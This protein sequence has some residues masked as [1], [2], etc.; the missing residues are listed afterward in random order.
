MDACASLGA[1]LSAHELGVLRGEHDDEAAAQEHRDD[2]HHA[3]ERLRATKKGVLRAG[4]T[5]ASERLGDVQAGELVVVLERAALGDGRDRVRCARGWL[6]VVSAKGTVMLETADSSGSEGEAAE[7]AAP[8]AAEPEPEPEQGQEKES[9]PVLAAELAAGAAALRPPATAADRSD[10]IN[11][12]D[13][14]LASIDTQGVGRQAAVLSGAHAGTAGGT[15]PKAAALRKTS[16][17]SLGERGN[18]SQQDRMLAGLSGGAAALLRPAPERRGHGPTLTRKAMLRQMQQGGHVLD[19]GSDNDSDSDGCGGEEVSAASRSA[20]GR[21]VLAPDKHLAALAARG[22]LVRAGISE[23]NMP[24]PTAVNPRDSHLAEV[25]LRGRAQADK[26]EAAA[27]AAPASAG[28]NVRD[29]QLAALSSPALRGRVLR[30][31]AAPA[32]AVHGP[33]EWM[34]AQVRMLLLLLLLVLLLLLLLLLCAASVAAA[35]TYCCWF[36][37]RW[38]AALAFSTRGLRMRG[39]SPSR[40]RTSCSA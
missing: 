37:C 17:P 21:E 5:M 1:S 31:G 23:A 29:V 34:L 39:R 14:L 13:G 10:G 32:E 15:A 36:Y 6:S 38:L 9:A 18:V 7:P 33:R 27:A 4:A 30:S 11:R 40:P 12:R 20:A 35:R 28:V 25:A 24:P 2:A 26:P 16:A 8:A 19:H 3:E 22:R